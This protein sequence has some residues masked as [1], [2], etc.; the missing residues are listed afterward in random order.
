MKN[1]LL[2]L[3]GVVMLAAI[4]AAYD[5]ETRKARY[6]ACMLVQGNTVKICMDKDKSENF[7]AK[8]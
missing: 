6:H 1:I 8:K 2:A 3:A 5:F 7:P 4:S